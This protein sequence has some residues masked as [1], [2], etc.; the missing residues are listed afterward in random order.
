MSR[1][2]KTRGIVVRHAPHSESSRIV[3]WL[4]EDHGKLTTIAKG[5][6]RPRSAMMGAFDQLYTCELIYYA[7]ERD[8]VFVTRE[9]AP[10]QERS[11][12]RS[13]WR[14]AMAGFYLT[15]LT[16]RVMPQ[17]EP[18][19]EIFSM[20]DDA[21]NEMNGRGCTAPMIFIYELRLLGLLGL[22]PKLD[23]CASCRREFSAGSTLRFSTQ[24]GGIVCTSCASENDSIETGADILAILHHWQRGTGWNIARTARCNDQQLISIRS[25]LGNFIV[26]HL[27]IP[28]NCRTTTFN[29]LFSRK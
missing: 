4:T 11:R 10:L 24:R 2:T 9:I 18:S 20:L 13:D 28:A 8:A 27:D 5:A 12:F 3:H 23:H 6:M 14:A 16:A 19:P 17:H 26:Y 22:S 25:L 29:M 1:L 21:L 7:Q 15:D